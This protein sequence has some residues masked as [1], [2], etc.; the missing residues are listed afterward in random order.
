MFEHARTIGIYPLTDEFSMKIIQSISAE[1]G[2]ENDF[3]LMVNMVLSALYDIF[4]LLAA[5]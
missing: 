1:N 4:S 3:F 5:P 2:G